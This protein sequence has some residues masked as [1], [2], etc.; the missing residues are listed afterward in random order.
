MGSF[1]ESGWEWKFSWRRNLFD[2]EMGIASD[3]IDQTAVINLNVLS[4][5]SWVWGAA[6]NGIFSSKS[7]YLCIK[8]EQSSEDH[9]LGFCQLWD[10][11]IPPRA[12]TFAWRLLWDR[13]PTKENL[14][15]RHVDLVNDLCPFCQSNSESASHLFFTC[16]KVLPLWWEFNTWVKEDRALHC[17]SMDHFLQHS[18]IAGSKASN[19]RRKIWWIAATRSIWKLRNDVIFHNQPFHISKL[20]DNTNFLTW[21][22]LRGWEKDFNV[23]FHQCGDGTLSVC[24]LRRNKVQAQ[25][26]FSEDELLSVVLM[27]NGRKVVCG[28]QTGVILLYSWGCFKDCSDRFT[29]LSSNSIDAML[30]LDED[31][32]ITGSENGI[33]NLVGILPNR[34]IQ[35]IAEHSEYPVECLAFSH[36]KKFLGSIAHDQMLKRR[37][38]AERHPSAT[39]TSVE[40]WFRVAAGAAAIVAERGGAVRVAELFFAPLLRSTGGSVL[41]CFVLPRERE[42]VPSFLFQFQ[43]S[44]SFPSALSLIS[45]LWD[46]DNILQGSGNTQRTEAGGA[47]DSDDDEMDLDDDP[48]KINKGN[49]RKN[50]N[51]GNA[52]GGSNNF[53]A[54]L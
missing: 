20:V 35:P 25:S 36:D 10:T 11:K 46:L 33:I 8:A 2:N 27:K 51:N 37:G 16:Q 15:R 7:A 53:F 38:G 29:D 40:A 44:F 28:S 50:A 22:W 54:D 48:S 45:S 39:D 21:S 41:C 42:R 12:L 31:R 52:L 47:V 18:S 34:V 1:C 24:N 17:R 14:S 43:H 23:P 9:Q 32:I 4:K 19:T 49:K 30:K 6:S 3:F 13:L 26:E 5:D